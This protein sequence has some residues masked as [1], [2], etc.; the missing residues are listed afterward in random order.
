MS[1]MKKIFI[2]L[3]IILSISSLSALADSTTEDGFVWKVG[4]SS[5]GVPTAL[6][7]TGYTG[8]GGNITIPAEIGGVP[9]TRIGDNAFKDN[10]SIT[11][12]TFPSAV[13][14][15]VGKA[16]FQGCSNVTSINLGSVS[17][18]GGWAFSGCS[19]VSKMTIP[20]T[21][22]YVDEYA[23]S[24][25]PNTT[26]I[27]PANMKFGSGSKKVFETSSVL[28]CHANT[29]TAQNFAIV[30]SFTNYLHNK[31]ISESA[32][33][34]VWQA[35]PGTSTP[36]SLVIVGYNGKGG[37]ITIPSE[38]DGVP[39]G[40]IENKV[41]KDNQSITGVTFPTDVSV[42][43]GNAAFQGCS[44]ITSISLGSVS[45]IEGWAF[46]GCS[47]V[48]KM[49]IPETVN[50]VNEFSFSGMPNTTFILPANL[51]F[52]GKH[53]FET[54]SVLYC[55]ANTVTAQNFAAV[56]N[57]LNYLHY[58]CVSESAPDFV[59]QVYPGT[60]TPSSL[61]IVGYNGQG[62][63]ITIPSEIDGI[64]VAKIADNA[65]KGKTEI[66][67]ITI[68]SSLTGI[69]TGAF[70]NCS[71]QLSIFL[72]ADFTSFTDASFS[73]V[74]G[75]KIVRTVN[76]DADKKLI[77]MG[78]TEGR[79]PSNPDY[80]W[81]QTVSGGAATALTI[82]G[83]R[84]SNSDVSIPAQIDQVPVT[85]LTADAFCGNEMITNV[86]VPSSITAIP[87]G[88]FSYCTSLKSIELPSTLS[89][90]GSGAFSGSG[91]TGITIPDSITTITDNMFSGCSSLKY[92]K[93]KKNV[94]SI[95]TSAFSNSAKVILAVERD[96][97]GKSYAEKNGKKYVYLCPAKNLNDICDEIADI[98]INPTCTEDG[99][100]DGTH[101]EM[102]EQVIIPA[103][104]VPALGHDWK[105][106]ETVDPTCTEQGYETQVC[107]RCML[108]EITGYLDPVHIWGANQ[109]VEP[110]C[111]EKGY[112]YHVCTRCETEEILEYLDP[113]HIW[114]AN[115]SVEPN[116]TEK[117]YIYHMCTRCEAEE[118]LEYLDPVHIWGEEQTVEPTCTEGGNIYHVCKLC[119]YQEV[120][121]SIDALGHIFGEEQEKKA[122]CTDEGYIYHVCSRCGEQEILEH[123][124]PTH[125]WGAEQRIE[126]TCTSKGSVYH[127]C[128]ICGY[129]EIIETLDF[130]H[131]WGKE[132]TVSA[133]CTTDGYKYHECTCC[134]VQEKLEIMPALGGKHT[135][136]SKTMVIS[137]S[138]EREG[139]YVTYCTR[140]GTECSR[141]TI[142]KDPTPVEAIALSY[143]K[144]SICTVEFM[145]Y[146]GLYEL[147]ETFSDG[148]FIRYVYL[149]SEGPT[150]DS[151]RYERRAGNVL[152]FIFTSGE[153]VGYYMDLTKTTNGYTSGNSVYNAK[154]AKQL[155]VKVSCN[156]SGVVHN[157][158]IVWN[159][160]VS[161]V[162]ASF[163]YDYV[164]YKDGKPVSSLSYVD[165]TE[166]R[167]TLA[168]PQ[169]GEYYLYVKVS[170][171]SGD[172]STTTE[173]VIYHKNIETLNGKAAT[174][175][176]NGL[177]DGLYCND[178]GKCLTYQ[179]L[180]PAPGHTIVTDEYKD[181]SCT[182]NGL[183]EGSHCSACGKVFT[184]QE[185][186]PS[187]GHKEAFSELMEPNCTEE[188]MTEG[189]YCVRCNI[190]LSGRDTIP[191]LGHTEIT[192]EAVPATYDADGLTEGKHCDVCGDILVAQ[193]K[194]PQLVR[195][196]PTSV[197]LAQTG[198][199]TLDL[200]ETL[201]L[202]PVIAPKDAREVY[203]WKSSSSKVVSVDK[204]GLITALSEGT[205]TITV[206]TDNG[207]TASVKVKVVD[208][209]K[210]TAV[211]LKDEGTIVI[212]LGE[213]R[214]LEYSF[215]PET[216]ES[217]VT[218]TSSASTIVSVTNGVV[219]GLKEGTAT[220]TVR[221]KKNSLTDTVK[222][223]VVDS[224]KPTGIVLKDEGTV[225]I[226]LGRPYTLE[227]SL[228]PDTAVTELTWTT[229]DKRIATVENGIV[230]GV[231]EGTAT[232]TVKTVRNSK[233]DT[234]KVKVVY[235]PRLPGDVNDDG[236]VNGKDGLRLLQYLSGW[237]VNINVSNSDVN[238]DGTVSGKDGVRLLQYL[239]GWD[240]VLK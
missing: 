168:V 146:Y 219:K 56:S 159:V 126:P 225:E 234:V 125:K 81:K 112:I 221:T 151:G 46:S 213:S 80:V 87:S 212:D 71:G 224:T 18:I 113:V 121:E 165:S 232:I 114:G 236:T 233:T 199:V 92:V 37:N 119:R 101:C 25:M 12:V 193:E 32:P 124:D 142:K 149:L 111:T 65:F 102:C 184:K 50:Y 94:T 78:F 239:S 223:Q 110:L 104:S 43:V 171:D 36:S 74:A 177:S 10:K 83:Y 198:T 133:T 205:A 135:P 99:L 97:Y 141:E 67:G 179:T 20:E 217:D 128:T 118:I 70:S 210:P 123:L 130:S 53:I 7:I 164:L 226:N 60:S 34:F 207:K 129:N 54:S 176:E 73:G 209:K 14:V 41:F 200:G 201:Q 172:C 66:T 169:S 154:D 166:P 59:W 30:S 120:I 72:P 122:T 6:T 167:Y 86:T 11:S 115:Q 227:Y 170:C 211:V 33:D 131:V 2:V 29:V 79:S 161:G 95:S 35:Y 55:Y 208:S 40:K 76:S 195:P 17:T 139:L 52:S 24:G 1:F 185:E 21:V 180:I 189:T 63:N 191:A 58:Q 91:L 138:T 237:S 3:I 15:S 27:L 147:I 238:G 47:S 228:L 64:P 163:T 134:G 77:S 140:C 22:N 61:V 203:T 157:G 182:E 69:G 190:T 183:T 143:I 116:C 109:T 98:V 216:A 93:I 156:V 23:L 197:S 108:S 44:N 57:Y 148:T 231:K 103:Q 206:T 192:D 214:T 89:Q 137:P 117:G 132:Q 202:T 42:T 215:L 75:T 9:V 136:G 220:I 162:K 16:A 62:G 28:Y 188:G 85:A 38:I 145:N 194:I 181:P 107:Q 106:G 196:N 4:S 49:T 152:R 186:I 39:V 240:V 160:S 178:C 48:S 229:S 26:F 158:N 144:N 100:I 45:T 90:I 105:A 127:I 31:C 174:C 68:P 150:K 5:G 88:A 222:V 8:E 235:N 230:T 96:S 82:I 153:H 175:L 51:K 84:G 218:W 13:S 19:S 204:S 155:S 173:K 187:L